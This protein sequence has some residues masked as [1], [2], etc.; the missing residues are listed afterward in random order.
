MQGRD[1]LRLGLKIAETLDP[2][3]RRTDGPR[4]RIAGEIPKLLHEV[5]Q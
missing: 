1:E 4:W 2:R 3:Q 5:P